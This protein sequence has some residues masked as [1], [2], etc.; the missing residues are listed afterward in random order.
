LAAN[1]KLLFKTLNY[2]KFYLS[3]TPIPKYDYFEPR[4]EGWKYKEPTAGY[5]AIE[6]QT[7]TRKQLALMAKIG[8]WQATRFGKKALYLTWQ[9]HYRVNDKLSFESSRRSKRS[10]RSLSSVPIKQAHLPR[11][12]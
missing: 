8:Y 12:V 9:P 7:D 1:L 4:V 11:I 3:A 10:A 5:G 2:I 6:Y